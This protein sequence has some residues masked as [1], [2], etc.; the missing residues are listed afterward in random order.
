M[1]VSVAFT[2]NPSEV[3]AEARDFLCGEPVK[4]NVMLTLLH[5][6]IKRPA[7]SRH[8]I[9]RTGETVCGVA[10][11]SP[12]DFPILLTAMPADASD[13]LAERLYEDGVYLPGVNSNAETATAFAGQWA[14]RSKTSVRP[15]MAGLQYECPELVQP[16]QRASGA[17]RLADPSEFD[18]LVAWFSDFNE[19]TGGLP[20]NPEAVTQR[21][22]G[23]DHLWVWGND[24]PV[25]MAIN[26]VVAENTVRVQA[27]YTPP[28]GRGKGYATTAVADLTAMLLG[29]GLRCT[30]FTD[31]ANPISNSIYRKLGYQPVQ[32]ALRF[33]FG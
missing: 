11:Q 15:V 9:L 12:L 31:L 26:S 1:S 32:S 28:G 25:A 4:N 8:W 22:M 23:D 29:R 21:T 14:E 10:F 20:I 19:H 27:V 3:L 5:Q 33:E 16:E 17:L 13:A 24:G 30:L 2:D 18:L 6:L 7:P